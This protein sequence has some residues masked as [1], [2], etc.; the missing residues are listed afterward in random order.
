MKELSPEV[1]ILF[2][3]G[4]FSGLKVARRACLNTYGKGIA[5]AINVRLD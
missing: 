1:A 4:E 2:T 3:L 5:S